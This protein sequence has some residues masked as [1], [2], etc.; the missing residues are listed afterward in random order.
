MKSRSKVTWGNSST[1]LYHVTRYVSLYQIC[2]ILPCLPGA[3]VSGLCLSS[4]VDILFY[5]LGNQGDRRDY[6]PEEGQGEREGERV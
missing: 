3:A 5:F 6:Q 4:H 2:F 1:R